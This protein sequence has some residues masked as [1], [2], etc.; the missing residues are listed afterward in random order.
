M[1]APSPCKGTPAVLIVPRLALSPPPTPQTLL[2]V[3]W[4]VRFPLFR[5]EVEQW[6][7]FRDTQFPKSDNVSEYGPAQEGQSPLSELFTLPQGEQ[8]VQRY[9]QP[10]SLIRTLAHQSNTMLR[11]TR[12]VSI[13]PGPLGLHVPLTAVCK[14]SVAFYPRGSRF[15]VTGAAKAQRL[16]DD[17][18][19]ELEPHPDLESTR[20]RL[21]GVG[22]GD[23]VDG[24]VFG[25]NWAKYT[26]PFLKVCAFKH[27][28]P[29][30]RVSLS[31]ASSRGYV[32]R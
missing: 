19:R 29:P 24:L 11:T 1:E 22:L 13:A 7:T 16:K 3:V 9:V 8:I 10:P 14:P 18:A 31:L 23:V 6:E 21:D 27:T 28:F 5:S 17:V 20:F 30:S 4:Y 25:Q 26:V 2:P 15:A 32:T 12:G